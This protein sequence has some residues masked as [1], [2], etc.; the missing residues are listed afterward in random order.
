VAKITLLITNPT[1]GD[2]I[3]L[4]AVEEQILETLSDY[5]FHW[6]VLNQENQV[7]YEDREGKENLEFNTEEFEPGLHVVEVS[8][9]NNITKEVMEA[10]TAEIFLAQPVISSGF[11]A[12]ENAPEI[13]ENMGAR[14]G[15][16]G[17]SS[18]GFS[19]FPKSENGGGGDRS[20]N[21]ARG[22][23][24]PFS[25]PGFQS[26]PVSLQRSSS[27][28]TA[29]IALWMSILKS[30][31]RLNVAGFEGDFK[32]LFTNGGSQSVEPDAIFKHTDIYRLLKI[33]MEAFF[34][35]RAQPVG[36][37]NRKKTDRL[38]N[39][40]RDDV[41]EVG[42]R[43]RT[44]IPENQLTEMLSGSNGYLKSH[45]RDGADSWNELPYHAVVRKIAQTSNAQFPTN[46]DQLKQRLPIDF[47]SILQEKLRT[48]L[49]IELIWSYWHEEGMLVQSI[50]AISQRFQNMRGSN[51]DPLAN[52]EID[53]LRP[54]SNVLWGMI[55]D[56]PNRLSVRRRAYEY[57]HHYGMSLQG[58]AVTGMQTADSRSKFLEAFHNMLYLTTDF[59]R[60]DDD[61]TVIADAFPLV[62]ALRDLH[63]IL[64]EGAHNQFGDLPST[65]RQEM[66]LQQWILSRPQLR[67]FLPSR[68]SVAYP[69]SWMPQVDAMKS[70]QG[71]TDTSVLHF[72]RLATMGEPLL[73][74]IRYGN[75]SSTGISNSSAANWARFW[76]QEIQGY[77]YAYRAVTG[78]DLTA[79]LTDNAS[80]TNRY[81][82]PSVHLVRQLE[83]QQRGA[84]PGIRSPVIVQ[85]LRTR[86][87][88]PR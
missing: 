41:I 76:R 61:T 44:T 24:E 87:R 82:P 69:E 60:Q 13:I 40:D 46:L 16:E 32:S 21:V 57:D 85:P 29:D 20:N 74:S 54:I 5:T 33:A 2:L 23:G 58:K 62:N 59:Y 81:L 7:V 52:M 56:E 10:G 68:A 38:L 55:Q 14:G 73:L 1:V 35:T 77:I 78:V 64:S 86:N 48:P 65:A 71:W 79:E 25:N 47:D 28:P 31:R 15:V 66:L 43:L 6:K 19:S 37:S 51:R 67:E 8:I 22:F 75:W 88:L 4:F 70:L 9:L 26:V 17:E 63:M 12:G 34:V 49:F 11:F 18:S 30:S 27:L 53:P 84:L 36:F 39:F 80:N 45:T 83:M 42:N 72:G 3:K 50:N